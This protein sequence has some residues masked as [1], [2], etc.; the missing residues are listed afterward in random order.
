MFCSAGEECNTSTTDLVRLVRPI[1][2]MRGCAELLY[3]Y[4]ISIPVWVPGSI[5]DLLIR[6]KLVVTCCPTTSE[7][8]NVLTIP[9][10]HTQK[11]DAK[12]ATIRWV[13]SSAYYADF[14]FAYK[15]IWVETFQKADVCV[16][17]LFFC[18][19]L[20]APEWRISITSCLSQRTN[21]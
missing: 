4:L 2:L 8:K 16:C 18:N 9:Y 20:I 11:W 3:S 5:L 13:P 14:Q 17:V 6:K 15:K 12:P 7:C 21:S 1:V 10:G 19:R